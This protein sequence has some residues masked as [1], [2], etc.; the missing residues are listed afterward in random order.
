M[1]NGDYLNLLIVVA[2]SN[3]P[4]SGKTSSSVKNLYLTTFLDDKAEILAVCLSKL[5]CVLFF[6]ILLSIVLIFSLAV[7]L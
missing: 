4:F 5:Y 7:I 1:P 3:S 2:F 6:S